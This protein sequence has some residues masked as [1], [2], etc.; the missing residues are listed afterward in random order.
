MGRLIRRLAPLPVPPPGRTGVGG[1][2]PK[3]GIS[4]SLKLTPA[5]ASSTRV[6]PTSVGQKSFRNLSFGPTE[7]GPTPFVPGVGTV[8]LARDRMGR[9]RPAP[10]D[11]GA[12]RVNVGEDDGDRSWDDPPRG[13]A[14]PRSASPPDGSP[15]WPACSPASRDSSPCPR[16][17]GDGPLPRRHPVGAGMLS[18]EPVRSSDPF[19]GPGGTTSAGDGLRADR[20]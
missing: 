14:T 1:I 6:G 16:A 17:E 8:N 5:T 19:K 4:P 7:V 13:S 2:V 11:F 12:E 3:P 9:S 18:R 15:P 20:R 10:H